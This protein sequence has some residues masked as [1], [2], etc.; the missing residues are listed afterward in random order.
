MKRR[1][2]HFWQNVKRQAWRLCFVVIFGVGLYLIGRPVVSL[3][4]TSL[5]IKHLEAEK[6]RYMQIVEQDSIFLENLKNREFLEQYAREK[7]FMQ[8]RNEQVF[9]IED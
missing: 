4:I 1:F 5:D 7:Y 3:I 9:I 8:Q 6:A 2:Q